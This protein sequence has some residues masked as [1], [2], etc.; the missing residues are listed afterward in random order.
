M[1]VEMRHG[2]T[3]HK[4]LLIL[5]G[6]FGATSGT[7]IFVDWNVLLG[8]S[9]SNG[10]RE[11]FNNF[12]SHPLKLQEDLSHLKWTAMKGELKKIAKM[13][14]KR[15]QETTAENRDEA[16]IYGYGGHKSSGRIRILRF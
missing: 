5:F 3:E 10:N 1:G 12:K 11:N 14:V 13:K 16:G 9:V 4:T 8:S 15:I 6:L 2:M 7:F